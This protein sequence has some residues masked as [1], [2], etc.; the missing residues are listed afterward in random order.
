MSKLDALRNSIANSTIYLKS[1]E[2]H[3]FIDDERNIIVP[4]SLQCIAVQHDHNIETVTFDCPR[5]WDQHDMS[6]MKI[7]INYMLSNG[8]VGMYA[9]DNIITNKDR[10]TF[11][12]T[13]SGYATAAK[14]NIAVSVCIKKID[15]DGNE[16]QHWNSK[17]CRDFSVAEGLECSSIIESEYPD[18]ISQI[19]DALANGAKGESNIY[20]SS[21][22]PEELTDKD[23]WMQIL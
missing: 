9:A 14:G 17:V 6:K 15:E 12:W 20:W 19:L 23:L 3:I 1:S 8:E 7:Y 21:T 13:V 4:N 10:M 16:T 18:I 2:E 22:E 5:Y 11:D